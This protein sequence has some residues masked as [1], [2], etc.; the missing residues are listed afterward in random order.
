MISVKYMSTLIKIMKSMKCDR[1]ILLPDRIIGSDN[2]VVSITEAYVNTLIEEPY[3]EI[4]KDILKELDD[5]IKQYIKNVDNKSKLETAMVDNLIKYRS[6]T[7]LGDIDIISI[8]TKI[9][10][11]INPNYII[12][13]NEDIKQDEN[14]NYC[15]SLK[16]KDGLGKY[17]YDNKFI[18]VFSGLLPINKSDKVSIE[19]Y[20]SDNNT[21]LCRFIIDKKFTTLYKY[22]RYLSI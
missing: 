16:A 11:N 13:Y 8:Y 5:T 1:Y 19:I 18:S 21:F 6:I 20:K 2:N 4:N 17:I 15:L 7:R 14:F 22:I 3:F 12:S 9:C 10:S